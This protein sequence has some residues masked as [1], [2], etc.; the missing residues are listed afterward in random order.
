MPD[1]Q[2]QVNALLGG[3]IDYVQMP[4]IDLFP[5]LERDP[6]VKLIEYNRLG[7]QLAFRFNWLTEPFD[8]PRVRRAAWYALNQTDFL[9]GAIG[10]PDYYETCRSVFVCGSRF[11]TA[12]GMDGLIESDF[13]RSKALLEEAGYD[14][15]PVVIIQFTG[16]GSNVGPIAARLLERGGF[17]VD[18][19]WMEGEAW[20]A[21]VVRKDPADA[22][23]WSA[24]VRSQHVVNMLNPLEVPMLDASCGDA[25]PGWPC[26]E[27]L[28]K[29]RADLLHASSPEAQARIATAIQLRAIEVSTHVP[30]GQYHV[31]L[32][33][34][35]SLDGVLEGPV[36]VFW[37]ISKDED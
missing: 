13:A 30:L 15:T 11:E 5:L 7:Y 24:V 17:A 16:L 8:D 21:R 31:P 28:E 32:G 35:A 6:G 4:L 12:A 29:L 10:N 37:N 23:G 20:D 33:V 27:T 14:G 25:Q 34:R 19:Q 2:H 18:I 26:D 36:P 9:A 22:G 3:E 1:P